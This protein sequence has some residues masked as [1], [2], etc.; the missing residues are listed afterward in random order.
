MRGVPSLVLED[1]V[2]PVLMKMVYSNFVLLWQTG[3]LQLSLEAAV[4][5]RM[6]IM[7]FNGL[8]SELVDD[9]EIGMHS[10]CANGPPNRA[11]NW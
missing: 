8:S 2:Q 1:V 11:K 4:S 6:S 9:T 5:V 10:I 3:F 7:D